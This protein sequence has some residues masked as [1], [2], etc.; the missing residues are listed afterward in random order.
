MLDK[1]ISDPEL[2]SKVVTSVEAAMLIKDGMNVAASGFTISGYPKAVSM[3]LAKRAEQTGEK[4]KINL[5][6]GASTGE[7]L[8]GELARAGMICKRLPY[9]TNDSLRDSINKGD[10]QYLD[11]HLSQ[12]QQYIRYDFLGKIDIAIIEAV[13]ITED[14]NIIP[15]SSVG[16]SPTFVSKADKV[17]V[18]INTSQPIGLEGMAD[19]Y[20]P[21]SPPYQ[22]PIPISKVDQRI[23]TPY[24]PCDKDKLAAI[25]ITDI[26]D[27]VKEMTPVDNISMRISGY[28]I[29][30]LEHEV[31]MGRLPQNLLPLQSGVGCVGNAVLAG[32]MKSKFNNMTCYT[33]V[34]QD[35]MLDLIDAGKISYASGT[36]ITTS[37]KGR[38]K[39]YDGINSYR[40]KIILRP[41]EIS[42]NPEV[43]RRLGVIAINTAIEADIYGN[44][45]S[46]HLFG[47]QMMN[48]IGGSGD[49][50]RNAYISIFTTASTAKDGRISSIVPMVTHHDHTEHD[51]MI[52]IT[53][54]GLADLRGLSTRERAK[55]IINNCA[56]PDYR[57]M[58]LDYFE[59]A[60]KPGMMHTPHLLDEAFSWHT[61][62]M[63]T[64][65]MK[66]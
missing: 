22:M 65:T 50:T 34:I 1:R 26:P 27:D 39:F 30:F 2:M 53:E 15:S 9:Q 44:I 48:G 42:N 5:L 31:K 8:D 12:V 20:V 55:L 46:T 61:R 29:E 6:T 59:R 37:E 63:N 4:I 41:Q 51:V 14:G 54:N 24:I 58:L 52:V 3:A 21:Q 60:Q 40:N 64:G 17:I 23:G 32:L 36:S 38:K 57:P 62:Y 10:C 19:I 49:F 25:V 18:E 47:S 45:N 11:M 66:M 28:L 7:E 35:S 43:I 13:A 56:H 16:C 33:E